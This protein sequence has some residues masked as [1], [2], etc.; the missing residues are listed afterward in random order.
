MGKI[1]NPLTRR[2]MVRQ[3]GLILAALSLPFP[4]MASNKSKATKSINIPENMIQ[5]FFANIPQQVLDDLK[6]RIKNTRWPDEITDSGWSY[7]A[8]L[9]YMKELADYWVT[10][11][12]WRKVEKE[13]NSYPNFIANIDGYRIHFLHVKGKGK[14][15][16]PLII[17]HGWPGSFI[18]MMK[19]IP[20]LTNDENISFDL[21]IPSV[22][23]FGFSDKITQPGCNSAFVADL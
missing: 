6:L 5:P 23:G 13:I 12:D 18:E 9:S 7:G 10:T 3:S 21:V 14:N 8:N 11:F 20:L 17:T 1:I 22:I 15:A 19:L 4:I 2:K 16:I